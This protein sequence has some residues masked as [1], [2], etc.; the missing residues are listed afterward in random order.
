MGQPP[1]GSFQ[2]H[3]AVTCRPV[4][5]PVSVYGRTVARACDEAIVS[6]P[7]RTANL[8]AAPRPDGTSIFIID[9]LFGWDAGCAEVSDHALGKI[10]ELGVMEKQLVGVGGVS[11]PPKVVVNEM[12]AFDP[13]RTLKPCTRM[14]GWNAGSFLMATR[15]TK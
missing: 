9:I 6:S 5:V 4:I 10:A 12:A 3:P 8:S 15:G 14:A 11:F 13:L 7:S 2:L 1:P